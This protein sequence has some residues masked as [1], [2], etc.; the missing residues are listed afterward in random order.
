M[1]K[2]LTFLLAFSAYVL[3][4]C[5]PRPGIESKRETLAPGG[6]LT[7]ANNYVRNHTVLSAV[8][9]SES[10]FEGVT[11]GRGGQ[12]VYWGA[13]AVVTPDS[14]SIFER[15]YLNEVGDY[16][17][18]CFDSFP[19][20]LTLDKPFTVSV[21]TDAPDSTGVL[22]LTC[23]TRSFKKKI[24]WRGGGIPY[25]VNDGSSPVDASL[26]FV[27][28]DAIQ[29]VWFIADSYFMEYDVERWPYYMVRD[30]VTGWFADQLPGG[31][32]EEF[33]ECFRE[34]LKYGTPKFAVWMMGMNDYNDGPDSPE[35]IW[36]SCVEEFISLCK[37]R[38]I[39][40]VLVTVPTVPERC[41]DRKT[42]WV[43][44]SGYRYIDWAA[45][46]GSKSWDC[47]EEDL[48]SVATTGKHRGWDA[49]YLSED[50]VHPTASGAEALWKQVEKDLPELKN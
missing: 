31:G 11:L 44:N 36:M 26:M 46:V 45:A 49:D 30:G 29:P 24:H 32:S 14:V 12:D 5:G 16:R 6:K 50:D 13:W 41:H 9:K 17:N 38:G 39:T 22:L 40:P 3:V 42:E 27:R 1:K 34:D 21:V 8:V 47:S 35:Q 48:K 10:A 43:R 25:L 19:H 18:V 37:E 23:G 33:I 15:D 4:S 2:T 20:G 7:L 28:G